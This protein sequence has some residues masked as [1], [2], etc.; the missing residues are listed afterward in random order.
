MFQPTNHILQ[1]EANM[2][3]WYRTQSSFLDLFSGKEC[4]KIPAE[5]VHHLLYYWK[6]DSFLLHII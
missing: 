4:A 5:K 2:P 1:T 3:V 6:Y